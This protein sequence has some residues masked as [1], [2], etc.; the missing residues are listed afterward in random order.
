MPP[1]HVC[2]ALLALAGHGACWLAAANRLEAL[3]GSR[4]AVKFRMLALHLLMLGLGAT[5]AWAFRGV[6]WPSENGVIGPAPGWLA[7]AYASFCV[8]VALVG[9]PAF[10]GRHLLF[11]PPAALRS[12]HTARHDIRALARRD[13]TADWITRAQLALPGNESLWIDVHEKQLALPRLDPALD[14]LSVAHLSDLHFTGKIGKTYFEHAIRLVGDMDADLIALTGDIVEAAGCLDW[15]PDL[16]GRLRA[17]LGLYFVLGNHDQRV[18]VG[19]LRALLADCGW[20]DL[21]GRW[22]RVEARG[23]CLLLAGDERPWFAASPDLAAMPGDSEDRRAEGDPPL[24]VLLAHTP[25]RY[26]WA[27]R[28]NFDLMLAGHTHGGQI[29]LPL[30]GPI[31]APSLHGV[32]YASGTF[33]EG[34]TVLHVSRGLSGLHPLR[35]NCPPELTKLVLRSEH[36]SAQTDSAGG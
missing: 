28:A 15:I 13:L 33:H 2:I 19:R 20:T 11:R 31:V 3:G 1:V 27:R 25:D 16:L 7:V 5:S 36:R 30:V 10:I 6:L 21:A 14:G 8:A 17:P 34:A 9:I 18:D 24:R 22:Q 29:R 4:R 32:K 23:R 26:A 12:N 35:W